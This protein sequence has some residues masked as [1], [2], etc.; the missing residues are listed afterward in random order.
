MDLY[1]IG[2]RI[3]GDVNGAGGC[4]CLLVRESVI[5]AL[6]HLLKFSRPLSDI[7]AGIFSTYEHYGMLKMDSSSAK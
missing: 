5:V 7:E 1:H 2:L 4:H 3:R 6:S